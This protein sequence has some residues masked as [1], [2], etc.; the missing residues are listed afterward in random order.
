[1]TKTDYTGNMMA[2]ARISEIILQLPLDELLDMHAEAATLAAEH[3]PILLARA[4]ENMERS[5]ALL[6]SLLNVRM[7]QLE[8][9]AHRPE[10]VNISNALAAAQWYR[11]LT[12]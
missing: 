4:K 12:V 9:R 8:N 7:V 11:M 1:M 10:P 5:V 3:D 6:K 2:V